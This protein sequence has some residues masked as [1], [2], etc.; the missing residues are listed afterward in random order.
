MKAARQLAVIL[1][2]GYQLSIAAVLPQSC[3]FHPSCSHYAIEALTR[4]GLLKGGGLA[5]WRLARCHPWG[6][7]GYDPVPAGA[8]R[9]E[10][11]AMNHRGTG[12]CARHSQ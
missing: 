2:K 4:H 1:V 5:V 7:E 8:D 12:C 10:D 3:R 11:P 6:G 9:A